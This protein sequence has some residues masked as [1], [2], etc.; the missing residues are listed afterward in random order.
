M[1]L[2]FLVALQLLPPKQRAVLVLRDVLGWRADECA[3]LL[4][5]SAAA[6]N[7]AL[8]RARETLQARAAEHRETPGAR[9]P[10]SNDELSSLLSRYIRAWELADIDA[11]VALLRE[12]ATLSMPP[13]PQWLSGAPAIAGTIQAMVFAPSGPGAFR[14]ATT[15]ANGLPALAAYKRAEPGGAHLPYALHLLTLD[16]RGIAAIDAFIDPSLF[17][18]FGLPASL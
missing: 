16:A 5:L 14:F 10:L 12:D 11:L 6:V 2:A 18:P 13:M 7:S 3:E 17:A 8:Q 4:G 1:G 9:A 15:E